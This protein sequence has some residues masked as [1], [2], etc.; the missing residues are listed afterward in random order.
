M[1]Q[2][3]DAPSHFSVHGQLG[4]PARTISQSWAD[5]DFVRFWSRNSGRASVLAAVGKRTEEA[6]KKTGIGQRLSVENF[7]Y[8]RRR[9]CKRFRQHFDVGRVR[10]CIRP[11]GATDTRVAG[12]DGDRGSRPYQRVALVAL[13]ALRACSIPSSAGFHHAVICPRT[14]S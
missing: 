13:K 7:M 9:G 11:F 12:P 3:I 8:R 5:G 2:A 10:S 6:I 14:L 4:I 1:T